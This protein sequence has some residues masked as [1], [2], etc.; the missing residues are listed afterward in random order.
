MVNKKKEQR[1]CY[2]WRFNTVNGYHKWIFNKTANKKGQ[3]QNP[4]PMG[5]NR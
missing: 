3:Y 4:I 1:C 2:K 5:L